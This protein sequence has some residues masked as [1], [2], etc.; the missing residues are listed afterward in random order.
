MPA[1]EQRKLFLTFLGDLLE[2]EVVKWHLAFSLS[3]NQVLGTVS[4][5]LGY[6]HFPRKVALLGIHCRGV[7]VQVC[8]HY[9]TLCSEAFKPKR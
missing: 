1:M 4:L 7:A 6:F 8:H 5:I 9:T 2:A 3:L